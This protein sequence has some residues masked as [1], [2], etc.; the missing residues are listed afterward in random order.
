MHFGQVNTILIFSKALLVVCLFFCATTVTSC[1]NQDRTVAIGFK[2]PEQGKKYSAG[3]EVKVELDIPSDAKVTSVDYLI[4]GKPF[5]KKNNATAV[6]L[7]TT[8]LP[9]GY[10]L[11]TAVVDNGTAKDTITVNIELKSGIK[12]ARFTYK[13]VNTFP[14][15]T[16]S[17]TEGLAYHSGRLLESTGEY[18]NS[19]LRWVDLQ[20]GKPL[21]KTGI[22]KQYFG[23]GSALIGDKI[24]ML[25]YKEH[26]GFV[27]DAKT[28][29]QLSTFP[30]SG[31]R[32]GWG[33]T[34]DG[35]RVL[36]TDGT[37]RIWFLNKDTYQDEGYLDVY[38]NDG[39]VD[40]LNELE[41]IGGKI[42]ANI[43]TTDKIAI[44]NPKSGVVEAYVDLSGLL[45]GKDKFANTDVL[46]GIAWDEAGKRLFVT[47]K[48]WNKLFEI[49]LIPSR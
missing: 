42:Y 39:Q 5:D 4:D 16:S 22:D 24:I 45:P 1:K 9:L 36:N 30:C 46:N 48:K 37:S 43:Y 33:L 6:M 40:Q 13:V 2:F 26:I 49:K 23:E 11:I 29:K 8:D 38:D 21:Q 20:S 31:A 3:D 41:Y 15:D 32:D 47:G 44:I 34:F 19:T 7:K 25:T 18:G 27:Y 14:H 12:P 35:A 10:R 28:L 17:Y